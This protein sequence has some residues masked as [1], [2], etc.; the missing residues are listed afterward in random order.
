MAKDFYEVLGVSKTAS[1]DEIKSAYRSLAKKYHPDLNKDNKEAAEKF[2]EINEANE[3]LSDPQKRRVY[4][5]GGYNMNGGGAGGFGGFDFSGFGGGGGGLDDILSFFFNGGQG[6][7]SHQNMAGEDI[8]VSVTL[9]FEEAATG[10]KR[11]ISYNKNQKC[12]PCKGTG[13]KDGTRLEKCSKCNGT[14][15]IQYM[16]E[17]MFRKTVNVRA[18]DN[19]KGTGNKILENCSTCGSK[20]YV[21]ANV[22]LP[23]DIPAGVDSGTIL[24]YTGG[25]HAGKAESAPSGD[26][27]IS[28]TV[29]P[30]KLLKRKNLD[31][32]VEV[33]I[34][35]IDAA[36]G[37]KIEVPTAYGKI[38][39]AIPEG[40]QSGQM[41]FIRGKGIRSSGRVGDLYVTAVVETPKSLGHEHKKI[42]KELNEKLADK[43]QQ[44]VKGFKD[45]MNSLYK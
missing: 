40:T 26:L 38:T 16:S 3:V 28:L 9:S 36:L 12:T 43:Q 7:R 6:G 31:L 44:K 20:G 18:C 42:L 14:G 21:R 4:D 29:T 17:G 32:F 19:C 34:S 45:T 13:A 41:F 5:S 8:Q 22:K 11:E 1:D 15:K 25:G 30:H 24:K 37:A 23:I 39:H 10:V 27:L 2:K 35:F 33:P